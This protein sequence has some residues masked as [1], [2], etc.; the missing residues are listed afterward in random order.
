MRI[1]TIQTKRNRNH[2]NQ[3]TMTTRTYT[4]PMNSETKRFYAEKF[5]MKMAGS[6]PSTAAWW[7]D[8]I[9][10]GT[11]E[12]MRE[13]FSQARSSMDWTSRDRQR[14]HGDMPTWYRG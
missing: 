9:N 1:F 13:I 7:I 6:L 5:E 3:E 11:E 8:G 4:L 10:R 12:D 2:K 14:E